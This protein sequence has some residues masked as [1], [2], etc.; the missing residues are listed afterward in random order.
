MNNFNVNINVEDILN[1]RE[2]ETVR[3]VQN[4]FNVKNY[5]QARL[6]DNEE[7]KEMTIRLLPFT[8]DGGSPFH[9]VYM[10]QVK[11]N[12]EVSPSGYKR[13]PC[14]VHNKL[15]DKCPFCETAAQA[16]LLKNE[17]T[18]ESER[19]KLEDV[20]YSNYAKPAWLVRCIERGHEEDGVKYW[21]FSDSKQKDGVYDKIYA[22]FKKRLEK[23][24]NIFDVNE[25]K[26]LCLNLSKDSMGKTRIVITDDDDLT[27]LTDDFELGSSW[28]NDTKAWTDVYTIKPYEYMSIVVQGGVPV[29]NKDLKKY[30][31]KHEHNKEMERKIE[32]QKEYV[33]V[34]LSQ[35]TTPFS[36][37]TQPQQY[38]S[39]PMSQQTSR[40]VLSD[41][42]DDLPF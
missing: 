39:N 11:V 30:V 27:P 35:V 20:E 1:Q 25:G 2:K 38:E 6:A 36:A 16:K 22:I 17:S 31:D 24:K 12:K 10:H 32:A 5:L 42:D 8:P 40:V 7:S 19:K 37:V 26:D 23:G 18:S 9:K 13:F 33:E 34:D 15:G 3:T 4:T 21:L 29:Y 41:D 28:I 14:P